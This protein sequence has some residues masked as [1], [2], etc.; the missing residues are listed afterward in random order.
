ME[1]RIT[2]SLLGDMHNLVAN[3]PLVFSP[4]DGVSKDRVVYERVGMEWYLRATSKSAENLRFAI[5][6]PI[7]GQGM[8]LFEMKTGSCALQVPAQAYSAPYGA[9]NWT[10]LCCSHCHGPLGTDFDSR[11]CPSKSCPCTCVCPDCFQADEGVSAGPSYKW[12]PGAQGCAGCA[13][14][15]T[16][17]GDR[18]A[19][20]RK[21]GCASRYCHNEFPED[22][23][24]DCVRATLPV[25]M[26]MGVG[27]CFECRDVF[28]GDCLD[29]CEHAGCGN[30]FCRQGRCQDQLF[31]CTLCNTFRCNCARDG[32]FHME[33]LD[34]SSCGDMRCYTCELVYCDNECYTNQCCYECALREMP[35]GS[36]RNCR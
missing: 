36:C 6:D 23:C 10:L 19:L 24:I 35:T 16:V 5:S 1:R 18:K 32:G 14:E 25:D 11:M 8:A 9:P 30:K 27:Q 15:C 17:C 3:L 4:S 29:E 28:C 12:R 31:Q 21:T 22:T 20:G 13:F 34:C 7:D 33:M 26:L 2:A